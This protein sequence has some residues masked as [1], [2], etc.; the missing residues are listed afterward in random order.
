MP[1]SDPRP[2]RDRDEDAKPTAA[3][4]RTPTPDVQPADAGTPASGN[5]GTPSTPVMKQPSKTDAE[6]GS[7]QR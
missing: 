2:A 1:E 6:R 7:S 4:K 3:R 5:A